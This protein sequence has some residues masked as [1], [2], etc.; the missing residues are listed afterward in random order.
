V[1]LPADP[2]GIEHDE[3][4]TGHE[5]VYIVLEGGGT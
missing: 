4:E 2:E 3:V 5:E 1:R